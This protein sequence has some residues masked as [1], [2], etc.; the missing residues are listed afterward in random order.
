MN[1]AS[2]LH[3]SASLRPGAPALLLGEAVHASYTEFASIASGFAGL[4]R[5]RWGVSA[6]DRIGIFMKNRP[7]YLELLYAAWWLGAVVVPINRKLHSSEVRWILEN[8]GSRLVITDGEPPF[9]QGEAPPDCAIVDVNSIDLPA[10]RGAPRTQPARLDADALAWLFYTSGTTGRPKGAMLSHGNLVAMSL[11]YV[12][13]VD[14]V[15]AEDTILYAAPMSHGA[16]LYNFVHVRHGARHAIPKSLGFDPVEILDLSERL[17]RVS[18]F[19]A[20]TMVRRL[21]IEA[22]NSGR[23]GSGIRSIVYGGAPMY[24]N[25]LEMGL[26]VLG[27]KLIQIYGQGETPMTISALSRDI[28][29]SR[30]DPDWPRRAASAGLAQSCVDLRIVGPDG[31][32]LPAGQSGEILVRGPTVMLGYWRNEEATRATLADGWLHTGDVGRIDADG[33][34]TLTDRVKDVIISGGTNIYPREVEE[35]LLRHPAVAAASVVGRP[36]EDWGEEV[37]AFVVPEAGS[38]CDPDALD[39]WCRQHMAAFKRPRHYVMLTALPT[40]NY[41]KILKTELRALL[42][43]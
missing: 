1:I 7:E 31:A 6:G 39:S 22:R 8:S 18:F 13:D 37:V 11:C 36:H 40:S 20:P 5:E 25:D 10:L 32:E 38:A 3:A 15:S 41:G 24:L 27:P 17:G 19:A 12:N 35:V 29:A 28:I 43:K 2:W 14:S 26:E 33:F 30:D 23:D 21:A 42:D 9:N 34:L 4:L 16:G